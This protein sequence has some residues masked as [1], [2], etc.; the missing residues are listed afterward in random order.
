MKNIK[1]TFIISYIIIILTGVTI[2]TKFLIGTNFNILPVVLMT[3]FWIFG[4]VLL[5]DHNFKE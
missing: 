5:I 2:A 4:G 3:I 1:R